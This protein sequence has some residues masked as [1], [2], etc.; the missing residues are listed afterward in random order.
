LLLFASLLALFWALERLAASSPPV[1]E[2]ALVV[3]WSRAA[4]DHPMRSA[5]A[6]ACAVLMLRAPRIGRPAR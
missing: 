1:G 3:R 2:E 6:L 4:L 5:L